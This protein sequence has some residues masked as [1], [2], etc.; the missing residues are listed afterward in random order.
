MSDTTKK[1]AVQVIASKPPM[2]TVHKTW[3]QGVRDGEEEHA[4]EPLKVQPFVTTPAEV[5]MRLGRTISL[6][7]FEFLR[8][9]IEVKCPCYKEEIKGVYAQVKAL[10][11]TLLDQEVEEVYSSMGEPNEP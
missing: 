7:E 6:G 9:D 1:P 11:T 4:N 5:S 3:I 10:T 8:I 2:V